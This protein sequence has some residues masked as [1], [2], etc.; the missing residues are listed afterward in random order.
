MFILSLSHSHDGNIWK[1]KYNIL[2]TT[3]KGYPYGPGEISDLGG[4][5]DLGGWANPPQSNPSVI[6]IYDLNLVLPHQSLTS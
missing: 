2:N 4:H 6:A 5:E 1:R 3:L